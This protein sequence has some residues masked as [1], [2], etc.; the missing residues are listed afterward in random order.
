MKVDGFTFPINFMV[1]D[2]EED[3]EGK[4]T[5]RLGDEEIMFKAFDSLKPPSALAFCNFVQVVDMMEAL[6]TN[7]FSSVGEGRLP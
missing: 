1:L 7:T 2:M 5:L 3:E 6:I 4:L